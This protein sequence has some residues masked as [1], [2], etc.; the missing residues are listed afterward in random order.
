MHMHDCRV[1]IRT[2]SSL[3]ATALRL[4]TEGK[5]ALHSSPALIVLGAF[6]TSL[7]ERQVQTPPVIF[8]HLDPFCHRCHR[9]IWGNVSSICNF[10]EQKQMGTVF[11]FVNGPILRVTSPTMEG[12]LKAGLMSMEAKINSTLKETYYVKS[13]SFR[14]K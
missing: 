2:A 12:N 7:C 4:L 6:W 11:Y 3:A 9:H 5:A 14:L 13:T 8:H 10:L 1:H